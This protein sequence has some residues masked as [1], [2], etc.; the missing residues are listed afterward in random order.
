M[1]RAIKD[2]AWV[3]PNEGVEGTRNPNAT[4]EGLTGANLATKKRLQTESWNRQFQ[5]GPLMAICYHFK[6]KDLFLILREAFFS[7]MFYF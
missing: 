3:V 2:P 5:A 1:R 6:Y 7:F 4:A